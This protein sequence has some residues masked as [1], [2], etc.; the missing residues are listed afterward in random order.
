MSQKLKV[1]QLIRLESKSILE[2]IDIEAL[3]KSGDP[4]AKAKA[5][6]KFVIHPALNAEGVEDKIPNPE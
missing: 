4:V 3:L 5:S 6:E 2:E 1:I